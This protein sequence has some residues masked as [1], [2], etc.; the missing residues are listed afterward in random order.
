MGCLAVVPWCGV[1][2]SCNTEHHQCTPSAWVELLLLLF[3]PPSL[4]PPPP[5]SLP[6]PGSHSLSNSTYRCFTS[7]LPPPHSHHISA[8]G[9]Q[10]RFASQAYANCQG[11]DSGQGF[12]RRFKQHKN[13]SRSRSAYHPPE[14]SF[15]V[16]LASCLIFRLQQAC[17][18]SHLQV[19]CCIDIDKL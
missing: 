14:I 4:L 3:S 17:I 15:L 19:L 2:L 9:L 7:P 16:S 12:H 10:F 5:P 11:P 8:T 6:S 18:E 1:R 13:A